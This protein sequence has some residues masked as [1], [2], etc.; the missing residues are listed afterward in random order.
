MHQAIPPATATPIPKAE[1]A[2]PYT[3]STPTEA[4]FTLSHS[5]LPKHNPLNYLSSEI[6]Q[7]R[8]QAQTVILLIE[9]ELSTLTDPEIKIGNNLQQQMYNTLLRKGYADTDVSAVES[10]V[11]IHNF[12]NTGAWAKIVE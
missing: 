8:A 10:M 11:S 12:L 5:K 9:R 4:L 6:S 1:T 2:C 3:F 7:D